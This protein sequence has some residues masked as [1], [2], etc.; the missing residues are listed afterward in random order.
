MAYS[1]LICHSDCADD[2]QIDDVIRLVIS[3]PTLPS[4]DSYQGA[5]ALWTRSAEFWE[6]PRFQSAA[7]KLVLT[8]T[9]REAA[10]R[11]AMVAPRDYLPKRVR[12]ELVKEAYRTS[13]SIPRAYVVQVAETTS[14]LGP[15]V[16]SKY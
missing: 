6:L 13:G 8:A 3:N 15:L 10:F 12:N 2:S 16:R 1:D 11:F 4:S 7:T 14:Y 5:F 9:D